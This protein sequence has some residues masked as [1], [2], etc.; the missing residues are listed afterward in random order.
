[1]CSGLCSSCRTRFRLRAQRRAAIL[2]QQRWPPT[3]DGPQ[4]NREGLIVTRLFTFDPQKYAPVLAAQGYV[5]IPQ[6][7]TDEFYRVVVRQVDEYYEAHRLSKYA[8]G[9]KQ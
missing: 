5:H 1:M 7:L 6:G 4:L 2:R 3:L 9:D 8:R